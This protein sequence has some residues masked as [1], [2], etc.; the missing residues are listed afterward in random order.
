MKISLL[1]F[2][3]LATLNVDYVIKKENVLF[4]EIFI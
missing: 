3:F 4:V 2:V 1:K